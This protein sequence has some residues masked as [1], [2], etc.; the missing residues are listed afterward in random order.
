MQK[1]PPADEGHTKNP[2]PKAGEVWRSGRTRIEVKEVA[3][4]D[5]WAMI[6]C[7][8]SMADYGNPD[9][10]VEWDKQQ[11]LVNGR[12]HDTWNKTNEKIKV[13]VE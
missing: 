12:F 5:R 10:Y 4:D 11:P 2:K 8:V 7:S 6:H 13:S 3:D 9:S 1:I